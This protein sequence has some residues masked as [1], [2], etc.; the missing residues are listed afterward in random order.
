M[1][2]G[3]FRQSRFWNIR[4]PQ[5]DASTITSP[6]IVVVTSVGEVLVD[7]FVLVPQRT[8]VRAML[9]PAPETFIVSTVMIPSNGSMCL[10]VFTM[11]VVMAIVSHSFV[12]QSRCCRCSKDQDACS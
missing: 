4:E 6:L 9:P 7:M 5:A 1:T 3:L 12:S 8:M 10:P 11:I 2:S